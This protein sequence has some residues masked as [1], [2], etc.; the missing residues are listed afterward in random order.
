[1]VRLMVDRDVSF[2]RP[3]RH[4]VVEGKTVLTVNSLWARDDRR[5]PALR[6]VSFDVRAG[7]IVGIAGVAGNGRQT[8]LAEV[9]SRLRPAKQRR[10]DAERTGSARSVAGCAREAGLAHV[11]GDRMV[12][13]VDGNASISANLMMSRAEP[14]ALEEGLSAR[15]DGGCRRRGQ[16]DHALRHP[17]LAVPRTPCAGSRAA[18]S[19][20]SCWPANSTD[21]ASFLLIDQPTRG[22]DI[23]A[24]E[25]IR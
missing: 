14:R 13:G 2:E 4:D 25:A 19:R 8:E 11:P 9:L 24:Q 15:L 18:T 3:A 23:G 20:R 1:M 5:H 16:D 12:R 7:E 6:D 22:V 10:G 21:D 17:R